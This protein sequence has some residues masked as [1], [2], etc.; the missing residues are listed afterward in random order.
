M[1]HLQLL[2]SWEDTLHKLVGQ[3]LTSNTARKGDEAVAV[4]KFQRNQCRMVL[5][6]AQNLNQH[7]RAW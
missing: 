6:N 4:Q 2:D 3:C 1:Q 5:G 7:S